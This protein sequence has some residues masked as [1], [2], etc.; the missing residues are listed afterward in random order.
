MAEKLFQKPKV[1]DPTM[2]DRSM[3]PTNSR[4]QQMMDLGFDDAQMHPEMEEKYSHLAEQL[5]AAQAQLQEAQAEMN[6]ARGDEAKMALKLQSFQQVNR[7]QNALVRGELQK[8][9]RKLAHMQSVAQR[10]KDQAA[11]FQAKSPN[12]SLPGELQG[13]PTEEE[14]AEEHAELAQL[15][16]RWE[17]D[18]AQLALDLEGRPRPTGSSA[19]GSQEAQ[20]RIEQLEQLAKKQ[21]KQLD[22]QG[23]ELEYFKGGAQASPSSS[24]T[25]STSG[26]F[27]EVASLRKDLEAAEEKTKE[28]VKKLKQLATDVKNCICS[29]TEIP[30]IEQQLIYGARELRDEEVVGKLGNDTAPGLSLELVL[31]REDPA[32]AKALQSVRSNGLSL[33]TLPEPL[34]QDRDIVLA[35]VKN[36]GFAILHAAP[37]LRADRE[38]ALTSVRD[39]G[40]VLRYLDDSLKADR[41]IVMAAVANDGFAVRHAAEPLKADREVALSAV[42]TDGSAVQY[43]SAA[44]AEDRRLMPPSQETKLDREI[45]LAA[46]KSSG[47]ALRYVAP[48]FRKDREVVLGAQRF[49]TR[50]L[51]LAA[52]C[53]YGQA[54]LR[55]RD[56]EIALTAVKSDFVAFQ[57]VAPE[58]AQT[59]PLI[60]LAA[61]KQSAKIFKSLPDSVKSDREVALAAVS[62]DGF[63][64]NRINEHLQIDRDIV[65][66]AVSNS[67]VL[68]YACPEMRDDREV[69]MAAVRQE[70]TMLQ[71]ASG[72][73]KSDAEV[74]L[75]AVKQNG[76]AVVYADRQ[77]RSRRDVFL[78][79]VRSSGSVL[80]W[81]APEFRE[82]LQ[83]ACAAVASNPS[84]VMFVAEAGWQG[85]E[86]SVFGL[87]SAYKKLDSEKGDLEAK[88]RTAGGRA[89]PPQ[90]V[91][92][93]QSAIAAVD[94]SSA[95]SQRFS[96]CSVFGRRPNAC[97][98]LFAERWL[99][100]A[101]MES[102]KLCLHRLSRGRARTL[103]CQHVFHKDC[104]QEM[105]KY[106][107]SD[108][109]CPLCRM[110]SYSSSESGSA[111]MMLERSGQAWLQGE[112]ELSVRMLHAAVRR[113]P[114]N[115]TACA[116]LSNHYRKGT[117]VDKDLAK[118][119]LYEEQA[120][121][122]F[123]KAD[124]FLRQR[125][126]SSSKQEEEQGKAEHQ[127]TPSIPEFGCSRKRK[128]TFFAARPKAAAKRSRQEDEDV[129]LPPM[130]ESSASSPVASRVEAPSGAS[131]P[132]ESLEPA[133]A[134]SAEA[135]APRSPSSPGDIDSKEKLLSRLQGL[136][137][138]ISSGSQDAEEAEEAEEAE[139]PLTEDEGSKKSKEQ[140]N[141]LAA[142]AEEEPEAEPCESAEPCAPRPSRPSRRRRPS[143]PSTRMEREPPAEHV[144]H[145]DHTEPSVLPVPS[146]PEPPPSED[147]HAA[148]VEAPQK[149]S[150]AQTAE[151]NDTNRR[152]SFRIPV[153]GVLVLKNQNYGA[154]IVT[155]P[156]A[157]V[158]QAM[159]DAC[160]RVTIQDEKVKDT[161]L[162]V[163]WSK[164][165]GSASKLPQ[166]ALEEYFRRKYD[167]V[168]AEDLIKCRAEQFREWLRGLDKGRGVL[169]QYY[170]ALKQNFNADT[171]RL[172][173]M[174][175]G[176]AGSVGVRAID[177]ALWNMCEIKPLGHRAMLSRGI[178]EL[179]DQTPAPCC[180]KQVSEMRATVA[181]EIQQ[182]LPQVL[183]E[184]MR[185]K[186]AELQKLLDKGSQEWKEK[187]AI[188]CDRRR[189][190]HNLVQ[191]L[192]GNIR[193]YCRVRPMTEA[194]AAH[195]CCISFP[196]PDEI[197]ISNADMGTKKSFQFNE[198]YRQNSSQE[199]LFT[200]IR[201]LVVSMLDGYN[202]CMFAYGQTGSGK[203]H[204]MQGTRDNPGVYTRTFNELF[205]V[206]KERTGWK[207]ELKGA[208]VEI[209]NEE[210]RDLLLG[211]GD[212]KQKLQVRQGKE[213][214]YVPG[215]TMQPVNNAEEVEMLLSTAQT[216]R[217]VAATD[218]NLH[219]S[220][221]HLAVQVLG[222]M[223]NPDGKQFLS[224]ITLVDLAGSERLAKS[225][226]SGDRAKEAIAINK[227]LSSLGDVIAARAQK[228][229]HTPYR[230]SV[231][232][233]F[234][235][236]S[237]GGDSKT[238][239]LLQLNPCGSHVEES[240]CSLNFGARVNAVEMKK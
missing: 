115:A 82:D 206:A 174:K 89:L 96:E 80:Q 213:G 17:K 53:S 135:P 238:L 204:S 83:I 145:M 41:E 87:S 92:K 38:I 165:D 54:W 141:S 72:S 121:S 154:A 189:K 45:A 227:S 118:A 218:M 178:C 232:T 50:T 152:K 181:V 84:A 3:L 144:G 7:S 169:L 148:D 230:N 183:E 52:V 179:A 202:V 9:R 185:S 95:L 75:A 4:M 143:R 153:E 133:A 22:Q 43:V 71:Y 93:V 195:G 198:I 203:T 191:E 167:Q 103:R 149:A 236:D 66:A 237:L 139:G 99:T 20:T 55:K 32:R 197:Q 164:Q 42:T 77:L 39:R 175:V 221:S 117:G 57:H 44:L 21:A 161:A 123:G 140:E 240:M 225:G 172:L 102:C 8:T 194:E 81:A 208:C 155:V 58:L 76:F 233:H 210:I 200:G 199:D 126:R 229:G 100:L 173:S 73:L 31:L 34:C 220:R 90:V 209:Y 239:M 64:L 62:N 13:M 219:S 29:L 151:P 119:K 105:R 171:S 6:R 136:F 35:A 51:R 28:Q 79:A 216:N 1:Y 24:E 37:E 26:S 97:H 170:P 107:T 129:L 111:S 85:A 23:K 217:T 234:L 63:L 47:A 150:L 214:N 33:E 106:C 138:D 127:E 158:R 228:Q 147:A 222:T 177:P 196:G 162:Y 192:K 112:V 56:P 15:H 180:K 131:R 211:P 116:H 65:L 98:E 36:T 186:A 27:E 49:P 124:G 2:A 188:E 60:A 101:A 16:E 226:V 12:L 114:H 166:A 91:A 104:I 30:C 163:Y 78:E 212:K 11:W 193:V 215:L 69:V 182:Q 110:S 201:D 132:D 5:E 190:L 68:G 168:N 113:D 130:P 94:M 67:A 235:Q 18:V 46:V 61:V 223:T 14:A 74:V 187:Y 142:E 224:A 160:S 157:R 207:I 40:F 86:L 88:L 125:E 205:K 48:L 137:E 122:A 25:L 10:L 59:N 108:D 134:S 159:V 70:G 19:E 128:E 156:N 120:L 109:D 146:D 231:L 184:V 176:G